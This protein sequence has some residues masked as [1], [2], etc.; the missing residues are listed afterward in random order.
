MYA[1]MTKGTGA[2]DV[3]ARWCNCDRGGQDNKSVVGGE[4]HGRHGTLC[5]RRVPETGKSAVPDSNMPETVHKI[6]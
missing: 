1:I 3:L 5:P 6:R 2:E 4:L